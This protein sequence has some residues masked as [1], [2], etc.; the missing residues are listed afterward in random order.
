M[1]LIKGDTIEEMA[2][3][4]DN[5]VDMVLC[6]LPYGTT[7]NK[8]DTTI[9][10]DDLWTQYK[11]ILKPDGVVVLFGSQ[12]FTTKMIS[13]NISWF[14]EQLIWVKNKAGSGL[15]ANKRHLKTHE[16]VIVF[17]RTGSY[18]YNP[19]KWWVND[20]KFLTQRRTMSIYGE[21]NNN[22]GNMSRKRKP[23]DGSRYPISL[24]PFKVPV[25]P[26]KN[27]TYK[28]DTDINYHPTQKPVALLEYLIKTYSN[29]NDV[30]LDNTMGSGSTG[31]AC[32]NTNRDFIGIELDEN[33]FKIAQKRIDEAR[34]VHI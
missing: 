15:R 23:D 12:P 4:P 30:V 8:W 6:D 3:L 5:S 33:Y 28:P 24:L 14:R 32:V 18:V 1:Q 17:S 16:E 22:Y 25:T 27:K 2:K 13:S 29:E 10:F 21:S 19:I 11:R 26:A 31:V 20:K 7:A 9:P 34:A